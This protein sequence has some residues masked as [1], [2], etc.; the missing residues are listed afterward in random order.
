MIVG[1]SHIFLFS[2]LELHIPVFHLFRFFMYLFEEE[3]PI[4]VYLILFYLANFVFYTE[5]IFSSNKWFVLGWLQS[6]TAGR[7]F[8]LR[9]R[10]N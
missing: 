1:G 10:K 8:F 7:L 5:N 2:Y 6:L 4:V 9:L 3:K